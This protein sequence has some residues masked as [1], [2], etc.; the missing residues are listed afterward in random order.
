MFQSSCLS[1]PLDKSDCLWISGNTGTLRLFS[2]L[3]L[4]YGWHICLS[5]QPITGSQTRWLQDISY[6]AGSSTVECHWLGYSFKYLPTWGF[7]FESFFSWDLIFVFLVF[8]VPFC[9]KQTFVFTRTWQKRTLCI[10]CA[11]SGMCFMR[12]PGQTHPENL[13]ADSTDR[14]IA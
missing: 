5:V 6:A 12:N 2:I 7:F 8:V 13:K 3:V 11:N 14:G 4:L 1:P 9:Y 10:S